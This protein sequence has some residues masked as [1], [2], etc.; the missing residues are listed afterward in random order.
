MGREV[1]DSNDFNDFS[2][3]YI[4]VAFESYIFTIRNK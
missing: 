3:E 1:S 2:T 4:Q